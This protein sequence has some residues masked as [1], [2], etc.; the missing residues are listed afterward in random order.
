MKL[1]P[2]A[3]PARTRQLALLGVLLSAAVYAVSRM[4]PTDT[5]GPA[6]STSNSQTRPAST[7]ESPKVMPQPLELDKL[8]PVPEPP[9]ASRNPFSFGT[10]PAEPGPPASAF[11][12]PSAP[13]KPTAPPAPMVPPIP[14]KFIGRVM[15]PE[16]RVV[17]VL[18]D[19]HGNHYEVT[20]GQI[21]DGRYR[22]VKIGE[23]SL[24]IEYVNGTGR[25]TMQL[26]GS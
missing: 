14:L 19:E 7:I 2:P 3:G 24:V 21:V 11:V 5:A 6:V 20:E 16:R 15:L 1:L 25:T 13:P 17:A 4:L 26:R 23:E 22:V 12:P 9:V 18:A 8:E 10:R